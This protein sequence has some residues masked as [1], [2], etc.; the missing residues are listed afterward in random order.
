MTCVSGAWRPAPR[1]PRS[2]RSSSGTTSAAPESVRSAAA[3]RRSA[4]RRATRRC[5][6]VYGQVRD[7]GDEAVG[8][9]L[10]PE[11]AAEFEPI[12][13]RTRSTRIARDRAQHGADLAALRQPTSMREM[14]AGR[15]GAALGTTAGA[16]IGGPI[17]GAVGGAL[18][19]GG[20]R[21]GARALGPSALSRR[22]WVSRLARTVGD[23]SAA[24]WASCWA[25][26]LAQA[27]A[28]GPDALLAAHLALSQ[29]DPSTPHSPTRSS[30]R[31]LR[32]R[33]RRCRR[34]RWPKAG[35]RNPT[36]ATS[37]PTWSGGP[38]T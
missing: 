27:A 29:E 18:G 13:Q 21:L 23:S 8:L 37:A 14:R 1:G 33:A 9:A 28:A 19:Y 35:R 4:S 24:S 22:A 6:T 2:A 20:A 25:P 11:R 32:T 17:G 12:R 10:G 36:R 3:Q 34:S 26:R 38:Q 31:S 5:A 16:A 30:G 15:V 7:L